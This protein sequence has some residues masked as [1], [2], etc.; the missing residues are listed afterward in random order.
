[1]VVRRRDI[2]RERNIILIEAIIMVV[3]NGVEAL[4]EYN[5]I[6]LSPPSSLIK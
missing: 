6:R 2:V 1:M 5:C 3:D 4:E